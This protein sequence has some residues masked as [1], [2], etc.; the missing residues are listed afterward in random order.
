[1]ET[2]W[3]KFMNLMIR[4]MKED[5][6]WRTSTTSKTGYWECNRCR[7]EIVRALLEDQPSRTHG[8]AITASIQ[9]H[10][11]DVLWNSMPCQFQIILSAS[12]WP[13]ATTPQASTAHSSMPLP[14]PE[15]R[16]D[17]LETALRGGN[18]LDPEGRDCWPRHPSATSAI[19]CGWCSPL[20]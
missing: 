14:R 16:P 11:L 10:L 13:L 2:R 18:E 7:Q 9:H 15:C 19:K 4:A 20:I 6:P 12:R 17:P 5:K 1:M 3:V 8:F